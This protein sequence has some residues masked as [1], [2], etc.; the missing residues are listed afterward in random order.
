MTEKAS[1]RLL[2][3]FMISVCKKRVDDLKVVKAERN[4]SQV[5]YLK[6][7]QTVSIY[8]LYLLVT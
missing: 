3:F 2:K 5:Q 1:K 4:K 8:G 7:Q 6:N